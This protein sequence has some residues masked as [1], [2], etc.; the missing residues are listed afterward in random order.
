[1]CGSACSPAPQT[2]RL[3]ASGRELVEGGCG[4]GRVRSAVISADS[5]TA[6]GCPV[7][8][9]KSWI[10]PTM[11]GNP[12]VPGRC[13]KNAATLTATNSRP[14]MSSPLLLTKELTL[15]GGDMA[16]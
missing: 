2:R 5:M 1:M 16:E 8:P 6:S 14:S 12:S 10:R 15:G 7:S 9:S 4:P 3:R 11:L 13:G